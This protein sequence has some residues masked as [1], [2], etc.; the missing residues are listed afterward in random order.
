RY[1][2]LAEQL[3]AGAEV[4]AREGGVGLTLQGSRGLG[5]L[6]GLGLDLRFE[7]D[8]RVGEVIALVGFVGGDGGGGERQDERS[9]ENTAGEREHGETS[10]DRGRRG[11]GAGAGEI[12]VKTC[13]GRGRSTTA[14]HPEKRRR[15]RCRVDSRTAFSDLKSLTF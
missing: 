1:H 4:V 11:V 15:Q 8:R 10:G 7:L 12:S 2:D 9:G 13:R 14:V 5:D 3:H 6:A